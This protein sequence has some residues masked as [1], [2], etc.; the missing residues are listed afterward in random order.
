MALFLG[1]SSPGLIIL[2]NPLILYSRIG[3][4]TSAAAEPLVLLERLHPFHKEGS[5]AAGVLYN[6]EGA[7]H[8]R[9]AVVG[10]REETSNHR[11]T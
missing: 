2:D 5:A 1:E 10:P 4:N 11:Q 6:T 3:Y 9:R 8:V 7:L